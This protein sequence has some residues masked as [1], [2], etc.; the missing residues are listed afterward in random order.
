M[1][2]ILFYQPKQL[3]RINLQRTA[4]YI[5]GGG[6]LISSVLSTQSSIPSH[7]W[8]LWMHLWTSHMNSSEEQSVEGMI[9]VIEEKTASHFGVQINSLV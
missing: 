3:L 5:P 8:F 1:A 7:L 4:M 9:E 2:G 6:Q